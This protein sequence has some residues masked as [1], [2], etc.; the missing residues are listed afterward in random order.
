MGVFVPFE[1]VRNA[2][3]SVAAFWPK[4]GGVFNRV[5]DFRDFF[6]FALR[7]VLDRDDNV[8][9]EH[10]MIVCIRVIVDKQALLWL[11]ELHVLL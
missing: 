11:L 7:L 8:A 5:E 10:N 2:D 4:S 1:E 6:F 3:D 9:L